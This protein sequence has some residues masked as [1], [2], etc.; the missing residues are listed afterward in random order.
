MLLML[1]NTRQFQ[2]TK[3]LCIY[4][5]VNRTRQSL[6]RISLRCIVNDTQQTAKSDS[7]IHEEQSTDKND[8]TLN[9]IL[10]QTDKWLKRVAWNNFF[11][12]TTRTNASNSKLSEHGSKRGSK[13]SV[14]EKKEKHTLKDNLKIG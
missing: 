1:S 2:L 3:P 10:S 8:S 9:N 13:Q 14:K 7:D 6:E 5:P 11:T 4:K 12:G